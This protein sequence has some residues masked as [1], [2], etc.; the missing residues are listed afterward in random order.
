MLTHEGHHVDQVDGNPIEYGYRYLNQYNRVAIEGD[1]YASEEPVRNLW[2]YS[3]ANRVF[4]KDWGRIYSVDAG[5]LNA[6]NNRYQQT[7][8]AAFSPASTDLMIKIIRK[9]MV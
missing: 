3:K 8:E 2:G 4:D 6:M 1:A 5:A 9:V 7:I